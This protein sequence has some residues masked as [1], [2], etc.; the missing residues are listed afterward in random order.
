MRHTRC[1]HGRLVR[2]T[3]LQRAGKQ[4]WRLRTELTTELSWHYV[5]QLCIVR[6]LSLSAPRGEA[7]T[8]SRTRRRCCCF[9]RLSQKALP[10]ISGVALGVAAGALSNAKDSSERGVD[11]GC[12]STAKAAAP[13]P[14][15]AHGASAGA[16]AAAP[17]ATAGAEICDSA[18]SL[19]CSPQNQVAMQGSQSCAAHTQLTWQA[20][21]APVACGPRCS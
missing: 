13:T 10:N 15:A 20:A 3:G 21:C 1:R 6:E 9:V 7:Y 12:A 17:A 14:T 5:Q 18:T 2:R 19:A 8:S 11:D 4:K 16:S